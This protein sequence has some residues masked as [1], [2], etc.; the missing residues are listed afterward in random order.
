MANVAYSDVRQVRAIL[1]VSESEI[2]DDVFV[3]AGLGPYVLARLTVAY[4]AHA[5]AITAGETSGATEEEL[6][7][8][9]NVRLL[10]AYEVALRFAPQLFMYALKMLTDGD[11]KGERFQ[12]DGS[13]IARLTGER[14]EIRELLNPGSFTISAH[15]PLSVVPP[16]YDPVEGY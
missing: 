12:D 16:S 6:S 10:C 7:L 3:N 2:P 15:N 8:A 4:P 11:W 14:D 1:G 13:L 5:A 9:A